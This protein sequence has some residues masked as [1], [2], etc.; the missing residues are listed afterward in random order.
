LSGVSSAMDD[1]KASA[2]EL[3]DALCEQERHPDLKLIR[4]L[5]Q[6]GDEA[7]PDLVEVVERDAGWP[8]IHAA[9]LLC[10]L[11]A[12][13]AL[14]ALR[15]AISRPEGH[16]LADWLADDA[17]EKFGPAALDILEAVAADRAVKWYPRAVACRV[18]STIA[19]RHPEAYGRVAAFLRG[20]LPTPDLDWQSYESYEALTEAVDDPQV[21]T[22]VVGRLCDLR[23]P[24]AHDLIGQL[25]QAGLVDEMVIDPAGYKRAY[26]RNRPPVGFRRQPQSLVHRYE[27]SRPPGTPGKPQ[28]RKGGRWKRRRKRR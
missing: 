20:L 13:E 9:L 7:V 8:Q 28:G 2:T 23:D 21:W 5:L 27:R 12:K 1:E 19:L 11:Q 10:E 24:G 22:S 26:R 4:A 25:F 17:L 6:R 16:D 15:R 14:P 18:M 3:V